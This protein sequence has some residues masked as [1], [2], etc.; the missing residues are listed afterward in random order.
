MTMQALTLSKLAELTGSRL[1]GN[2]NHTISG[3]ADLSSATPSQASFLANPRYEKMVAESSAGVIFI[4]K[5]IEPEEGK[6]F[7]IADNPSY[8]FQQL[9][10]Y[11]YAQAAP[12]TGFSGIHPSAVI[13]ETAQLGEGVT[14]GPHVTIDRDVQVGAHTAIGPNCYIG[15]GVVVGEDTLFHANVVVREGCLIGNRVILQ[16]GVVIGSCGYGFVTGKDYKHTKLAQVGIVR[17]CDDVEVGANTTIDRARFEVTEVGEGTKIDNQVQIGHGVKIGPHNLIV[18]QV[19]MAG[20]SQTG[21]NVVLAGKSAVAGHLQ[22]A[23]GVQIAGASAVTK[24]LT[25]PGGK[26]RG[27]P[28]EPIDEY[29]RRH[30][31][32]RKIGQYVD[33]IRQLRERIEQ[34]ENSRD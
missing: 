23:D 15:P 20:S 13:H 5:G 25:K 21:R 33:E 26:Y 34:L 6:N 31:H 2:A 1:I 12:K 4:A 18:A 7:L 24:S 22:V 3:V 14:V 27:H 28:A 29:Q 9:I 16:P 30:V 17:I 10:D 19:A 8:A 11:L 32:L